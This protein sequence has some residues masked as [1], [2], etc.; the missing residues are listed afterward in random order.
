MLFRSFKVRSLKGDE[1]WVHEDTMEKTL[2]LSNEAFD[3]GNNSLA[4]FS[5]RNW[6]A[7]VMGGDFGG[8][9]SLTLYGGWNFTENLGA[10]FSLSQALGNVSDIRYGG[11]NLVHQPFP[12]WRYSPFFKLGAGVIQTRPFTTL[13]QTQDRSDE[14]VNV[15]LGVKEIGRAS[16]RERVSSP[17]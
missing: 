4:D 17:A 8:A 2:L 1:G 10:E 9:T 11:I 7:G 12:E 5:K 15:G 3:S 14:I 16:C 13:I 6:E